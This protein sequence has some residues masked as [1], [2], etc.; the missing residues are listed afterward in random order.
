MEHLQLVFPAQDS[1]ANHIRVGNVGSGDLEVLLQPATNTL[2][3]VNISTS[4]NH[5]EEIWRAILSRMFDGDTQAM[6]VTINDFGATP[7]VI[8]LRIAQALEQLEPT[9]RHDA[10]VHSF[11][12]RSFV[13]MA[14]RQRCLFLLDEG[15]SRE[16]LGC[17]MQ[18]TSP[19]LPQQGIVAQSDDGCVVMLGKIEGRRSLVI[20]V[21]GGFQ[22]GAIGE[23]SGAK[24][25]TAL[26]LA[27]EDHLSGIE[28]QVILLL[29]TGG[30]RLQEANLGLAAIADIHASIVALRTKVPVIGI[31]AGTVGCFGG[32]S[33]AAGL[34]SALIVTREARLSL[35][36]PG[37]IEQE[38]GV[39]EFEASNRPFIWSFTGGEQRYAS[40]LVDVLVE[41][42]ARIIRG[43]VV[44][45]IS[46]G[47]PEVVRCEEVD[48]YLS[49]LNQ[50]D[51]SVQATPDQVRA[52]FRGGTDHE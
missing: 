52:D 42:D 4:I 49:I 36:G 24:I 51:T 48:H 16:L 47:R 11:S 50:V 33:L 5:R 15:S 45:L 28:T 1:V 27:L 2:V 22:G 12:S 38:A 25:S 41:D 19:W 26:E 14:M 37:V 9:S 29:E 43:Q 34:C 13:E 8:K 10:P 40:G 7:G 17:E 31:I 3:T 35:N 23:V 46:K 21:E 30:V 32:M 20:G 44:E 6:T 39:T 18:V